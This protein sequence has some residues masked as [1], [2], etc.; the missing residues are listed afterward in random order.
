MNDRE[1]FLTSVNGYLPRPDDTHDAYSIDDQASSLIA[2]IQ[3]L[4]LHEPGK[5]LVKG[6]DTKILKR[7]FPDYTFL[8]KGQRGIDHLLYGFPTLTYDQLAR[9]YDLESKILGKDIERIKT[10]I[11]SDLST[12]YRKH[13]NTAMELVSKF[14]IKSSLTKFRPYEDQ[15]YLT[16]L[17]AWGLY[18]TDLWLM[19]ETNDVGRWLFDEIDSYLYYHGLVRG[20]DKEGY[21]SFD[22]AAEYYTY[23][24]YHGRYRVKEE[25]ET[26]AERLY[27]E[28]REEETI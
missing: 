18:T 28:M 4:T 2:S 22:E 26:W 19:S 13:A 10:K 9:K 11:R 21:D 25:F 1:L 24:L 8:Q 17:P 3:Y 6:I 5:V 27:E 15:D 12:Y 23:G 20:E 14:G 16:G 7:L